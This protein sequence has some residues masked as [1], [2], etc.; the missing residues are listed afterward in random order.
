[1]LSD[2][3]SRE[4]MENVRDGCKRIFDEIRRQNDELEALLRNVAT[5][6]EN[7]KVE[8]EEAYNVDDLVDCEKDAAEARVRMME[9]LDR[10]GQRTEE[11]E[12]ELGSLFEE[13]VA[14]LQFLVERR[15]SVRRPLGHTD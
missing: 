12:V 15:V 6:T 5:T 11:E 4:K 10:S 7:L 13:C 9:L 14:R 3:V 1:M 8:V 2:F